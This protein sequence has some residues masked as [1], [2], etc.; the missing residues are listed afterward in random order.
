MSALTFTVSSSAEFIELEPKHQSTRD[1]LWRAQNG[2]PRNATEVSDRATSAGRAN[3]K[4]SSPEGR[5]T[6]AFRDEL[7]TG[8]LCPSNAVAKVRNRSY[9]RYLISTTLRSNGTWVASYGRPNVLWPSAEGR[10]AVAETEPYLAEALA[11]ADARTGIDDRRRATPVQRPQERCQLRSRTVLKGDRDKDGGPSQ[12]L[13][14]VN[15]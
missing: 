5:A 11:L 10:L 13:P 4:L 12:A 8:I 6:L 2:K 1:I 14:R 3:P 15:L 9:R 7:I